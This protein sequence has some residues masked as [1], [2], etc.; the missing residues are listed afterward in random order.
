MLRLT[1][2]TPIKKILTD[3]EVEDLF[4]PAFKG[5]LNILDGHAPLL[6]TLDTGIL[7]Y[8]LKGEAKINAAAISWGYMEVFDNNVNLLAETAEAAGEITKERAESARKTAEDMLGS[9][10]LEPA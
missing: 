3:A 7:R 8:R 1:L 2:V 4:V 6:T 5:E 9:D 10:D